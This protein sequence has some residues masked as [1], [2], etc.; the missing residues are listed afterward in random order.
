MTRHDAF[1]APSTKCDFRIFEQCFAASLPTIGIT[2]HGQGLTA[3]SKL[4]GTH[5][6][7]DKMELIGQMRF[8]YQDRKSL[9]NTMLLRPIKGWS[10]I[11]QTVKSVYDKIPQ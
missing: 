3:W 11:E 6:T 1:I 10:S 7:C 5:F 9:S 8:A 4:E 2:L